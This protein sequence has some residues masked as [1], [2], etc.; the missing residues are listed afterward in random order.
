MQFEACSSRLLTC[1]V[2]CCAESGD[3]AYEDFEPLLLRQSQQRLHL[4][5]DTFDGAVD[6]F[7]SKVCLTCMCLHATL[8]ACGVDTALAGLVDAISSCHAVWS[9]GQCMHC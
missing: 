4:D 3:Q 9:Y 7:F 8:S 5:F 1:T 6:E 2:G